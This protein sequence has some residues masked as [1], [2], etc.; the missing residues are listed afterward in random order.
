M[1]ASYNRFVSFEDPNSLP[2]WFVEDEAKHRFCERLQPTKE[3]IALE[4]QAIK[5]YN[6]RPSKKVEQA[7]ARKKKRLAKAMAKIKKKAQVIADQDINE[8]S[9]MKQIQK[10]YRKEKEKHKEEKSYV[11]NRSFNTAMGAKTRRG[12]KM[13]DKRMRKDQRNE[14]FRAKKKGGNSRSKSKTKR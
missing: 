10:M 2:S 14:K 1:D 11:V 5:E 6:A 9:K 8:A 12:V 3:E 13:V 4:K 7:K